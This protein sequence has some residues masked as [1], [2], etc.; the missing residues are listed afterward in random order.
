M[1]IL[2]LAFAS[3]G[4]AIGS[5]RR[6]LT[7]PEGS[8]V[9]DLRKILDREHPRLAPLWGRLAVAVNGEL[10]T[11]EARLEDGVEVALL[12]PV[13]GGADTPLDATSAKRVAL[14][15]GPIDVEALTRATE[16]P[17]C[18]AVLVFLGNV[19]N[20][21]QGRSVDRLT[22]T[23]YRPM[24]LARLQTIVRDL[25]AGPTPIQVGLIHRLG[26]VAVGEAS[27]AIVVASAHRAAAYE[28]SRKALERLKAEVP[29]W[30]QEHYSDG[31][32]AWREE[33][34]LAVLRTVSP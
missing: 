14:V 28:A 15:D 2:L 13:S 9:A 34:P 32:S 5:N 21:H 30:K 10:T 20:H 18:G 19:R 1:R 17:A 33:E 4:D 3:V 7:L 27:V 11:A 12:P 29:I 26:E 24:A 31:R 6:E 25:E 23:A 22:Y 8:T 16:S